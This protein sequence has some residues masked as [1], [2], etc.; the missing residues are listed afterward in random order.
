MKLLLFLGASLL[1]QADSV[2]PISNLKA[3][4]PSVQ[5]NPNIMFIPSSPAP[6]SRSKR[7]TF[8]AQSDD[9]SCG[10]INPTEHYNSND[11]LVSDCNAIASHAASIGPGV[12]YISDAEFQ[13]VGYSNFVTVATS[14]TCAY[15]FRLAPGYTG[16][17][18]KVGTNDVRFEI[19]VTARHSTTGHIWALGGIDCFWD[20]TSALAH[21]GI[22]SP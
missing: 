17:Y 16:T 8:M 21:F 6:R 19:T 2:P 14:G 13:A 15:K 20:G 5:I 3:R 22:M 9:E 7:V 10:E 4:S 18:A 1:A 11:P 12:F